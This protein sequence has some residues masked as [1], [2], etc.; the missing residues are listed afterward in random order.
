MILVYALMLGAAISAVVMFLA[1]RQGGALAQLTPAWVRKW[2][3]WIA[4]VP[5]ALAA[6]W[7]LWYFFWSDVSTVSKWEKPGWSV[8]PEQVRLVMVD[9]NWL[10]L[11]I[12]ILIVYLWAKKYQRAAAGVAIA[13]LI[14]LWPLLWHVTFHCDEACEAGKAAEAKQNAEIKAIAEAAVKH[15]EGTTPTCKGPLPQPLKIGKGLTPL[16]YPCQ[17]RLDPED[18]CVLIYSAA[19]KELGKSCPNKRMETINEIFYSLKAA[20]ESQVV[21]VNVTACKSRTPVTR[22]DACS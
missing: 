12:L 17:I 16:P 7:L 11:G 1:T 3:V 22:M 4:A 6:I 18:G 5:L 19:G 10:L 9:R 13:S 8:V 20:E 2:L 14:M 21:T 15:A